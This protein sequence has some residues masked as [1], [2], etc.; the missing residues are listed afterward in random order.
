[1]AFQIRILADMR[2][3]A[4][5]LADVDSASFSYL[6][7]RWKDMKESVMC[8]LTAEVAL[9][10]SLEETSLMFTLM[11]AQNQFHVIFVALKPCQ[12]IL[13]GMKI[14]AMSL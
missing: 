10:N 12:E 3:V 2:T 14:V 6:F 5:G 4:L 7:K 13:T 9:V 1:M 8:H 11:S